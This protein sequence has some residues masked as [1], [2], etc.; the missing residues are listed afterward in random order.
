MRVAFVKQKY[1]PYGGGEGYLERLLAASVARGHETHLLT[2]DWPAASSSFAVHRVPFRRAT[3]SARMRSF[4]AAAA[5]AATEGGFDVVF[6]LDR[7]ERQDIWRAG[8]GVHRVWIERRSQFEPAL[9]AWL[10]PVLPGQRALLDI[11][12]QCVRN[13]PV[14]IA[15]SRVVEA[16]LRR[17]Y[18][19][20]QARIEVIHNGI[21]LR[22]HSPEG[23]GTHRAEQRAALGMEPGR[24]VFLFVGS[25]FRRKGLLESFRALAGIPEAMLLVVGRDAAGPWRRAAR[26]LGV[27]ARVRFVP[28]MPDLVPFYHA[29]DVLV[30]PSW[31]ESFGFVGLEAMAC[32]T[33]CVTTPFAGVSDFVQP[34]VNGELIPTP[35]ATAE[36]AAALRRQLERSGRKDRATEVAASVAN[37]SLE[38]N[39]SRTLDLIEQVGRQDPAA[40]ERPRSRP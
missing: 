23:R 30:F 8:E 6:S 26:R 11:E 13:T 36:L 2:T 22:R 21:D 12:E 9:K 34:G 39:L 24:P 31:F 18:P 16:D 17:V 29:A 19:A 38:N 33:P 10:N 20:L 5:R 28:P 4:S 25:G 1:V 7:T 15:N 35:A 32:G 40:R 14:I 27:E 3:R 37:A